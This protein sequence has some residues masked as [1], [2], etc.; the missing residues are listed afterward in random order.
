MALNETHLYLD[1]DVTAKPQELIGEL[2]SEEVGYVNLKPNRYLNDVEQHQGKLFATNEE[3]R[4][5][6]FYIL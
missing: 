2:N 4:K 1:F 6:I 3:T 5:E